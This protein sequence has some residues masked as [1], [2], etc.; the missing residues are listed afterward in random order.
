MCLNDDKE[1]ELLMNDDKEGELLMCL[2]QTD[3]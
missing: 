2:Y 3:E 1:G